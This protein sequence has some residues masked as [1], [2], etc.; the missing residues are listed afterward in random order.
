MMRYPGLL[1]QWRPQHGVSQLP[2]TVLA[3]MPQPQPQPQPQLRREQPAETTTLCR[4]A[5]ASIMFMIVVTL[6]SVFVGYRA[7]L[8]ASRHERGVTLPSVPNGALAQLDISDETS[9][10]EQLPC[11]ADYVPLRHVLEE[12]G[13][14]SDR[15]PL[16]HGLHTGMINYDEDN[17]DFSDDTFEEGDYTW[18]PSSR[19]RP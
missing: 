5:L 7:G 8:E 6:G 11:V 15:F 4:R 14:F 1:P 3:P 18:V 9:T 2:A 17:W 12:M 13:L 19:A 10:G 16:A